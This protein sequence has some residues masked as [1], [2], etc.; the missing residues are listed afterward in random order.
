MEADIFNGFI[1]EAG[2]PHLGRNVVIHSCNEQESSSSPFFPQI[3][4]G[5]TSDKRAERISNDIYREKYRKL[6]NVAKG[7]VFENASLCDEVARLQEKIVRAKEERRFLLRKLLN[8]Q[9]S[10]DGSVQTNPIVGLPVTVSAP[11]KA[12]SGDTS[13]SQPKKKNP[14]KKRPPPKTTDENPKPR[15]KK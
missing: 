15:P 14:T 10:K 6:K 11:G 13:E 5:R 4:Q 3:N 9:S 8:F 1:S 12:V 7:F 2:S